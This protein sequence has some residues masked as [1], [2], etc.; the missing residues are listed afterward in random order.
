MLTAHGSSKSSRPRQS[1]RWGTRRRAER[2]QRR[3]SA[4]P[5]PTR[6][7]TKTTTT[8]SA[9]AACAPS[10]PSCRASPPCG[11][12]SPPSCAETKQ[13]RAQRHQMTRQACR[14]QRSAVGLWA[15][16]LFALLLV[17]LVV[18]LFALLAAAAVASRGL[19]R[20][21]AAWPQL[22][23]PVRAAACRA[24]ASARHAPAAS[25]R[26]IISEKRAHRTRVAAPGFS[27]GF[28]L[29]APP[30]PAAPPGG[31]PCPGG[32]ACVKRQASPLLHVP[33]RWNS[34]HVLRSGSTKPVSTTKKLLM[35]SGGPVSRPRSRSRRSP[36][37]M[38]CCCAERG[39][40]AKSGAPRHAQRTAGG[41][42]PEHGRAPR[43]C[44]SPAV[45][46][47]PRWARS[48]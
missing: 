28:A 30:A 33:V 29:P 19:R 39:V 2:Q 9:N 36:I 20:R 6:T 15:A 35:R 48:R 37:L 12:S 1:A 16:R 22:Q 31:P 7:T 5:R 47:C 34:K 23:R 10:C 27:Q 32:R 13:M 18:L 24:A 14:A 25:A 11:A 45:A 4:P 21:V 38:R 26:H 44:G 42:R 43:P 46:C 17:L 40:A 3:A 8:R 41:A